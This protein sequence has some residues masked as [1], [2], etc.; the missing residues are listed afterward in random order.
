MCSL[1]LS[2][3]VC[4]PPVLPCLQTWQP[5]K[6]GTQDDYTRYS[7]LK[8]L[9]RYKS[10]NRQS[11]GELFFGFL[12]YFINFDYNRCAISIRLGRIIP[13]SVVRAYKSPKNSPTHWSYLS[14]EE[15][16]DRT[17]TASAV[18]D[19]AIFERIIKVFK[20]TYC[21]L[22]N[23]AEHDIFVPLNLHDH[24][25]MSHITAPIAASTN[26]AVLQY[27]TNGY[28]FLPAI[29]VPYNSALQ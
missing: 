29:A 14:I 27:T 20:G 17:N 5:G 28:P 10:T 4:S 7:L 19:P 11:L 16:F 2:P 21:L 8:R 15:P 9:V 23:N 3:T 18:H 22:R 26:P 6:F 12:E 25:T 24:H 1:S 13:K